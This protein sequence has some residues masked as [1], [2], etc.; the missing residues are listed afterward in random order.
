MDEH[1]D[2]S[3]GWKHAKLSGHS[4]EELVCEMLRNDKEQQ[5]RLLR[6]LGESSASITRCDYG[7]LHETNIP[8]ILG[9]TTKNKADITVWLN[10]GK[11]YGISVKKSLAG[12][13]FLIRDKNFIKGFELQYGKKI[14]D[15]IERAISLFWGSAKDTTN[16]INTYSLDYSIRKYEL[17]KNRLTAQTLKKYDQKMH[18]DLLIWFRD[19]I[20]DIADYCFARGQAKY[21]DDRATIIWYINLLGEHDIDE[22]H[23]IDS[24]CKLVENNKQLIKYGNVRGGTTIKLPFGFVQW[25]QEQM[26][27][28]H[29]YDSIKDLS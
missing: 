22:I 7:G 16:I 11:K 20:Y 29:K 25:H 13:V 23:H 28:H 10:N 26:Q 12:Q 8:S 14:P 3:S 1:R 27:F 17:H 6:T 21:K 4:N 18:D 9:G 5:K 24:L 2:R 15:D 19:N